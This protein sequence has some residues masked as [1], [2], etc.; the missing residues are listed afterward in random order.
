MKKKYLALLTALMLT[1]GI[2]TGVQA[3]ELK[4]L[5]PQ[6]ADTVTVAA[7]MAK[8]DLPN[9]KKALATALDN[10][11]TVNEAKEILVQLY[12]YTGFPRSLNALGTLDKL[13]QERQAAGIKDEMG[14]DATP[15]DPKADRLARGTEVQTYISGRVVKNDFAP[16]INTFLREHL[17]YDIF[18]RDVIDWQQRE[19]ATVGALAGIGNV[20]PQL[21]SHFK[22]SHFKAAM[23]TGLTPEQLEEAV[24]VLNDTVDK[25]TAANAQQVLDSV[26]NNK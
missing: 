18:A 5:T 6:Q 9:L 22:T 21:T 4:T 14:A 24:D 16:I 2:S 13:V 7:F 11:M 3:A 15:L 19:L 12:A 17:F 10:G 8:G 1:A 23:N 20:N 25:N 26:L